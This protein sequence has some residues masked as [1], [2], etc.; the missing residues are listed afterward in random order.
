MLRLNFSQYCLIRGLEA[1]LSQRWSF[2]FV[3]T[4]ERV[5]AQ[6][7]FTAERDDELTFNVGDVINILCKD[8]N[9]WWTGE[10]RGKSGLFPS[11]FVSPL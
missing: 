6:F 10:L 8:D 2:L 5:R 7:A 9:D 3:G 4:A 1:A 11:N